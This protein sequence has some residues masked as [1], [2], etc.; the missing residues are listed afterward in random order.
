M[1]VVS[2]TLVILDCV[3]EDSMAVINLLAGKLFEQGL[4]TVDYGK[5]T[6]ERELHHPTGLPTKPFCIAFPHADAVDVRQS[7]LALA[8]LKTPVTF[9]NMG[10]PDENLQVHIVI[11]LANR[12]PVEQVETLRN[13]ASLFGKQEKLQSLR[14]QSTPEA[15]VAWL[16]RELRLNEAA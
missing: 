16:G 9:K 6:C 1:L 12:E 7:A 11:M 13:L 3:T 15:V 10:D 2:E 5:R 14:D 8:I 4:V